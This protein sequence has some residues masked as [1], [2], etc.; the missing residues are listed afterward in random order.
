M[1]LELDFVGGPFYKKYPNFDFW[2]SH[3]R[4]PEYPWSPRVRQ[5]KKLHT[6]KSYQGL[7]LGGVPCMRN[8]EIPKNVSPPCRPRLPAPH[9]SPVFSGL[10]K[11]IL[12]PTL[13]SP[14][15]PD[16]GPKAIELDWKMKIINSTFATLETTE[17]F[18]GSIRGF[19]SI[20]I[21]DH[22]CLCWKFSR[23]FE[24]LIIKSRF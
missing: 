7:I 23:V 15:C 19:L 5:I 10:P 11:K 9:S 13:C 4:D 21:F 22:S 8:V 17:S 16:S 24:H 18:S 1:F 14:R 12:S 2:F 3:S 20:K 6:T